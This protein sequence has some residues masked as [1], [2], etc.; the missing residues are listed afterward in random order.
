MA[1][2]HDV[3]IVGA[4]I[5]GSCLALA[6]G[7]SSKLKVGLVEAA[8]PPPAR[9]PWQ[10]Y[11]LRV[12]AITHASENIFKN[13]GVWQGMQAQRISPFREMRVWD[14]A[15][16]GEIHFDSAE[17][18]ESHLGHIIENRVIQST[19]LEQCQHLSNVELYTPAQSTGLAQGDREIYLELEGGRRLGAHLL[20]G[21]DGASSPVR[22]WA[23]ISSRG[24]D[25][26]QKGIVATVQTE[27][28][29]QETAWQRFLPNGP[30]AFLPLDDPYRCSIVWSTMPNDAAQLLA[31]EDKAFAAA[32]AAAFEYRLGA[33]EVIGPRAA[34]PLRLR[35]AKTYIQPRLALVGDAAHTIHPLAGQGVN[36]GLLDATA[37]AEVVVAAQSSKKELGSFATL[38]HFERWRKGDNLAMQLTMDGFKRLFGNTWPPV[39]V[40]RNLGLAATNAAAPLKRLIMYRASGLTGDLPSLA[41]QALIE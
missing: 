7:R 11:D 24:W 29:H 12:S 35:H 25:Y 14:T 27:K 13:L 2:H 18:G 34:F 16:I 39:R 5:V 6:L 36:L 1:S 9:E 19:L 41:R 15:G 28:S 30:L 40:A 4:G 33:I 23:G 21:A 3:L 31:L 8:T 20:V 37:L 38:R 17:I 22:Q 10:N 32:L 26:Q